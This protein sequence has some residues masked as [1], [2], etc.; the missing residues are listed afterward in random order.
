MDEFYKK[1]ENNNIKVNE[2]KLNPFYWHSGT[3]KKFLAVANT[4]A[5]LINESHFKIDFLKITEKYIS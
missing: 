5:I 4:E 1:A 3:G 2:I